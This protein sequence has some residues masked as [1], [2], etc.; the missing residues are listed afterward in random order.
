M[1]NAHCVADVESARHR[2]QHQQQPSDLKMAQAH[3]EQSVSHHSHAPSYPNSLLLA[4]SSMTRGSAPIQAATLQQLQ[5]TYGNRAVQRYLSAGSGGVP[6]RQSR[7]ARDMQRF[8]THTH[9][10][11]RQA[12][13]ADMKSEAGTTEEEADFR[14]ES[15]TVDVQ[16]L[17]APVQRSVGTGVSLQRLTDEEKAENLKSSKF[18][19]TERL[20]KA[21]DNEPVLKRGERG[22]PVKLV[23]EGLVADGFSMPGSVKADGALDGV[24][25]PETFSVITKFQAKH[26]LSPDGRVGRNTM[27]QLD[28]LA[29]GRGGGPVPP[30]PVPVPPKPKPKPPKPKPA[31]PDPIVTIDNVRAPSTPSAMSANRIPPRVDTAVNVF[32]SGR[33]ASQP[34]ITFSVEGSGGSNGTATVNGSA[35]FDATADATLQLKGGTQ[36]A[37]G[38]AGNLRLVADM[39]AGKRL[40]ASN[41][42]SVSSIPQN[43][44]DAFVSEVTGNRRGFV[45]QDGWESDS[46]TFADLDQAEISERVEHGAKSGCFASF[47]S[48]NSSYLVANKLTKDTH[49]AGVSLLTSAGSVITNQTCMFKDKRT[50]ALDIPMTNSGFMIT[51]VNTPPTIPILGSFTITTSKFGAAA[52]A[53]GISSAAGTCSVTK[54]QTV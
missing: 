28:Q 34:P 30:K 10:I 51:R 43:Y 54:T 6:S 39:G 32:I 41:A 46:G 47:S 31:L 40:V 20:E 12:A 27:R 1:A 50:G 33:D 49:S 48:T 35:T 52:T 53:K 11:Q 3:R 44:S 2:P 36:T 21:F 17:S 38:S 18:A 24:F 22:D 26:G 42:F 13:G 23:Q 5:Q 25:G 8:M 37:P 4:R 15:P 7:T 29:G 16:T 14:S 9:S 45:V 19:G